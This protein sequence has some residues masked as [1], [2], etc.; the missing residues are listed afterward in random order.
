MRLLDLKKSIPT[1][2]GVENATKELKD[3]I[4]V[5]VDAAQGKIFE[6]Y[7]NVH[8]EQII[9]QNDIANSQ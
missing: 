7:A 4:L 2:I 6:G 8:P 3:G 9:F 1:I 5:T